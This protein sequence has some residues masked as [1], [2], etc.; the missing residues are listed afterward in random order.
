MPQETA[1][2]TQT[3]SSFSS[4]PGEEKIF[5]VEKTDKKDLA[6]LFASIEGEATESEPS[7]PQSPHKDPTPSSEADVAS[8]SSS[9]DVSPKKASAV[10]KFRNLY[11]WALLV[12]FTS[13]LCGLVFWLV[14]RPPKT[15][16]APQKTVKTHIVRPV[17]LPVVEKKYAFFFP[18]P[19][20]NKDELV[21]MV[22]RIQAV[23]PG[24][25]ER[26]NGSSVELRNVIYQF[27]TR[28][29]PPKNARRYWARIV[30]EQLLQHLRRTFPK[31]GIT[32]VFLEELDRI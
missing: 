14:L 27:L 13:V 29:H 10:K 16:E 7:L 23:G 4:A 19:V 18:A 9:P 5:V 2:A 17:V 15:A 11:L 25:Q 8:S 31:A 26:M 3:S 12:L 1:P 32:E 22:L 6:E 20:K 28:Q 30:E 24:A 21:S